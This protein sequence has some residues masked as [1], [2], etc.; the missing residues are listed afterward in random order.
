[1]QRLEG[2]LPIVLPFFTNFTNAITV[3]FLYPACWT[4]VAVS[5]PFY[6]EYTRTVFHGTPQ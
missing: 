1:M 2:L 3:L 5:Y 6:H 4:T